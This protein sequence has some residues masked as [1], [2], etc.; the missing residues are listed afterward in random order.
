MGVLY[1][2]EDIIN[3]ALLEGLDSTKVIGVLGYFV[4]NFINDGNKLYNLYSTSFAN[5][6]D[7][8]SVG[9]MIGRFTNMFVNFVTFYLLTTATGATFIP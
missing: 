1:F 9:Q 6:F 7:A 4:V 3:W 8:M 5:H 2:Q